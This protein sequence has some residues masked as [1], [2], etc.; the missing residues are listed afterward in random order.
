MDGLFVW[1]AANF[2]QSHVNIIHARGVWTTRASETVVMTDAALVYILGCFLSVRAM[3]L[4]CPK[5][6]DVCELQ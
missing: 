1:L 4:E 5:W 6:L 3:R 2:M